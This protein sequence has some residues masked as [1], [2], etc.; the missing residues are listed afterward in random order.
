MEREYGGNADLMNSRVASLSS[1]REKDVTVFCDKA[2]SQSSHQS[3]YFLLRVSKCTEGEYSR[4]R[5]L[6]QV[7][8]IGKPLKERTSE[9]MF[10]RFPPAEKVREILGKNESDL[11]LDKA[12][13]SNSKRSI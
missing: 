10:G 7:G 6:T 8:W 13:S 11:G 1:W 2:L 4:Q 5:E 12:R 3:Q 9:I